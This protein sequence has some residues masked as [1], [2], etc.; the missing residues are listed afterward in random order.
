MI[1]MEAILIGLLSTAHTREQAEHAAKTVLRD[2][3]HQLAEQQRDH[4]ETKW[5]GYD[6]PSVLRKVIA[7]H[8]AD[9]IDPEVQLR[10]SPRPMREPSSAPSTP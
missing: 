4:A 3:A 5:P 10:P 7:G 8:Q 9:L 6:A 2:H 1:D